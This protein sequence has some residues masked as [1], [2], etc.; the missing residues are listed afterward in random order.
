MGDK[1]AVATRSLQKLYQNVQSQ[2]WPLT[3]S[4]EF[5]TCIQNHTALTS[6]NNWI[7]ARMDLLNYKYSV[8]IE[9]PA[10]SGDSGDESGSEPDFMYNPQQNHKDF[11]CDNESVS[12]KRESENQPSTSSANQEESKSS[13]PSLP[14]LLPKIDLPGG[15]MLYPSGVLAGLE[16]L[17]TNLGLGNLAM[18]YPPSFILGLANQGQENASSSNQPQFITIPLSM[19]VAAGAGAPNGAGA[20]S[21]DSSEL[22]DLSTGIRK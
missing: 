7:K 18:G 1:H 5:S 6:G 12:N 15:A 11:N 19:A 10:T 21:D 17:G 16:G 9:E 22:Q 4:W 20:S 8:I 3:L 2:L 14:R 13:Q